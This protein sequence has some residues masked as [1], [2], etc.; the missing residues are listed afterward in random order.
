LTLLRHEALWDQTG[1]ETRADLARAHAA[2]RRLALGRV[3]RRPGAAG[4]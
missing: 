2:G 1:D 4:A 3:V